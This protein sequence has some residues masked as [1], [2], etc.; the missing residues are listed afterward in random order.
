M[1]I[2]KYGISKLCDLKGNMKPLFWVKGKK[3]LI[4]SGLANPLNFEKTVISLDLA[5]PARYTHSPVEMCDLRDLEEL[6]RLLEKTVSGWGPM[7]L[8]R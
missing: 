6:V 8:R 7:D 5:F 2:A 4:F 1:S 3:L